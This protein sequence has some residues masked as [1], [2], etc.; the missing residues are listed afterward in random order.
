[1]SSTERTASTDPTVRNFSL[2]RSTLGVWPACDLILHYLDLGSPSLA[3]T[4][5]RPCGWTHPSLATGVKHLPRRQT[6]LLYAR[7]RRYSDEPTRPREAKQDDDDGG[8][9]PPSGVLLQVAIHVMLKRSPSARGAVM[10]RMSQRID[11]RREEIP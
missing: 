10:R 3:V 7:R 1:M 11:G 9:R 2:T 4:R 5:D 8:F 6:H